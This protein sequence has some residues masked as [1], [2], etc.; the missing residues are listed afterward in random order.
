[1]NIGFIGLGKLGLPCALAV[2]SRGHKVVG[3]DPS[4][5]VKEIVDT[6]KLQYQEIW[7]QEHLEKSKIEI[8]GI[9]G[10]VKHSDIIFVPIQT[11]HG[12]EFEGIT[13]IPER[14]I[15]FDYTPNPNHN[16]KF[17]ASYTH[18]HFF[19]GETALNLAIN[20]PDSSQNF[21]LDTMINF[22]AR[23]RSS[24]FWLSKGLNKYFLFSSLFLSREIKPF[25]PLPLNI[26]IKK[27]SNK[28]S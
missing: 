12:E 7:A 13:R 14:R 18:H 4:E 17:G 27:F 22:S 3:F 9:D 8:K 10:V 26:L 6:K 23:T 21:G 28:S 5:Q 16:V 25:N 11:P 15:D 20:S 2:E 24:F 1:M 19:P